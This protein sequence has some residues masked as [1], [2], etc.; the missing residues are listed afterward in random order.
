VPD[1]N[2]NYVTTKIFPVC[3]RMF[4]L[5]TEVLAC[6]AVRTQLSNTA[7]LSSVGCTTDDGAQ[8][9]KPFAS[10]HWQSCCPALR[11]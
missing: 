11:C 5:W 7:Q 9:F 1:N 4:L 10:E 8:P 3:G 2:V 6:M